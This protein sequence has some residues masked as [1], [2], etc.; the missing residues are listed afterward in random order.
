MTD[1]MKSGTPLLAGWVMAAAAGLVAGGVSMVV[2][3][4]D[5]TQAVFIGLVI[6][7][8]AGVILGFSR[9]AGPGPI[10]AAP[11]STPAVPAA[12]ATPT[13]AASEAVV[14]PV[15]AATPPVATPAPAE[16]W[17]APAHAPVVGRR[18]AALSAARAGGP[19]DLKRI[20]G[21]GP[22]LETLLHSLGF[23][24]FD[25]V[26]SWTPE[27]LAWVDDNLEGFKGRA[28][29]DEWVAQA[30]VLAAGGAV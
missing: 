8:V 16:V 15:V 10:S 20:K 23:Y 19:D 17:T 12:A 29:R 27:E 2:V 26:A 21:V 24:H 3:G 25:Q 6:C 5:L 13:P 14:P 4:L 9:A 28:S 7:V 1:E 18:P 11:A 30:Q 22:K